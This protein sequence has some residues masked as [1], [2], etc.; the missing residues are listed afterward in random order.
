M[1]K[2]KQVRKVQI[3][4]PREQYPEIEERWTSLGFKSV[5]EAGRFLLTDK[6]DE[7]CKGVKKSQRA[8]LKLEELKQQ[9]QNEKALTA[10][11]Q[12]KP[13]QHSKTHQD[14]EPRIEYIAKGSEEYTRLIESFK[15][16]AKFTIPNDIKGITRQVNDKGTKVYGWWLNDGSK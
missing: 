4:L 14:K 13:Y 16:Q 3:S 7:F 10:P 5:A 9:A 8:I 6:V 1:N 11:V 2:E 15:K 12:T